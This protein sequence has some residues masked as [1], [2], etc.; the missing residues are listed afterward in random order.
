MLIGLMMASCACATAQISLSTAVD[1]AL[2]KD[3]AVRVAQ[4]DL[5]K[6]KASLSETRDAYIP[7]VSMT[8]G[9]GDGTGAPLSVPVVF[10]MSSQSLLFNFSQR[11]NLRSAASGV[12]AAKLALQEVLEKVTEDVV[13]TYI[14]LDNAEQRQAAK[15]QAYGYATRLVTIVGDRLDAGQDTKIDLLAARQTAA[16]LN[17]DQLT[18]D[19]EVATLTEHLLLLL[20]IPG[21]HLETIPSSV[22]AMPDL[23]AD[24]TDLPDSYGIRAAMATARSKQEFAFGQKRYKFRPEIALGANYNRVTTNH[25]DYT[26]YY[27]GFKG[28]PGH[29][30]SDNALSVGIQVQIPL[31]DRGHEARAREAAADA[32]H[33][34]FQAADQRNQFLEGRFKLQHSIA[35]LSARIQL[36]GISREYAQAQLDAITVQL[37]PGNASTGGAQMTPKDEQNA[38]LQ[39]REKYV[40]FLNAQFQLNQVEINLLR[41]TGELD[42]WVKSAS[43]SPA[44]VSVPNAKP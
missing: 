6:A 21:D 26:D 3:P 11:D 43:S 18:T 44:S 12:E 1:L 4:A 20:G 15:K 14:D 19:D 7:S 30:N 2:H 29:P 16:Q 41:Q 42:G 28:S 10:G 17:L 36:A 13:V 9:Y 22:P 24:V 27:P 38:R 31:L 23:S 25:T 34:L 40:D 33:A 35:E 39:E 32:S 5:D 37:T 8:G